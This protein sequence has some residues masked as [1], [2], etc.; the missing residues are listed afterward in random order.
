[1]EKLI[2]TNNKLINNLLETNLGVYI[3]PTTIKPNLIYV[4]PFWNSSFNSGLG[5][6]VPDE[7]TINMKCAH[8]KFKYESGNFPIYNIEFMIEADHKILT[9]KYELIND[10]LILHSNNST[11]RQF[12]D[13]LSGRIIPKLKVMNIIFNDAFMNNL[14]NDEITELSGDGRINLILHRTVGEPGGFNFNVD[15]IKLNPCFEVNL[16]NV[17]D[18]SIKGWEYYS[19]AIST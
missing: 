16:N 11:I 3:L 14:G 8:I 9:Y 18:N 12:I 4:L 2:M 7:K 1:M 13:D 10:K 5:Y 6:I 15:D 19:P 17:D